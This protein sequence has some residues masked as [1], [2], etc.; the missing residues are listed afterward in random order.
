MVRPE[1]F[2]P[3]TAGLEIRCSVLLSYGRKAK[4]HPAHFAK[5]TYNP[6]QVKPFSARSA[7]AAAAARPAQV[8]GARGAG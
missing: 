5:L 4:V 3:P 8:R 7:K 2:E 1:G 6:I